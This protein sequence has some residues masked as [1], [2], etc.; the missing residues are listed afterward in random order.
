MPL[1]VTFQE[2]GKSA[3]CFAQIILMRQENDTKVI[4]FAPVEARA[5]HQ[6]HARFLQHLQKKLLVIC[7]RVDRRV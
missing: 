4:W 3:N 1:A 7:N 2:S 5:L 6:H